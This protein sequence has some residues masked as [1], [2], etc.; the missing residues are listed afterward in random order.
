LKESDRLDS[1]EKTAVDKAKEDT[2]TFENADK[3]AKKAK[4]KSDAAKGAS[5]P[6]S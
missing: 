1:I 5:E 3:I 6:S 4:E 2:N